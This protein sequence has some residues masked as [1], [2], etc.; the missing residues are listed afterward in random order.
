VN[1]SGDVTH[2]FHRRTRA[3]HKASTSDSALS[4]EA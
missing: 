3:T 2:S 4:L 1:L